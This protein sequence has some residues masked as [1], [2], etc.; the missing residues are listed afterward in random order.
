[1]S[2]SSDRQRLKIAHVLPALTKGGA[3]K[4]VVDLANHF[5]TSAEV[6]ILAGCPTDPQLLQA[7]ISPEVEL[8]F[9][10]QGR[11]GK[12]VY[13][14]APRWIHRNWEWLASRDIIHCHL[15]FGS[16]FGALV[17][18][19]CRLRRLQRPKVLET[20]HAVGMPI[21]VMR[22]RM[23][24]LL[25]A[26]HDGFVT[27][28]TDPKIADFV[29]NHPDLPYALI[30]NGIPLPVRR[31]SQEEALRFREAAGIPE[32]ARVV[33]TIG[34]LVAERRPDKFVQIF[35]RI[36]EAR[37]DVHFLMAGEGPERSR[38]LQLARRAGIAERLHLPGLARRAE[39]PLSVI[40]L[41]LTL[42]VGEITGIAALEAIASDLPAVA[43][44]AD[45]TYAGES[46]W[47][48]SSPDPRKVA[49]EV[50]RLLDS[51]EERRALA[52][53][54]HE[55]LVAKR[56]IDAA[57]GAYGQFYRELLKS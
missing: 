27:M 29:R 17:S 16:A 6:A 25:A 12:R 47:I 2:T 23:T 35:A 41:Y 24:A 38:I 15:T 13:A 20:Y 52:A 34:R 36:A 51:P 42:N 43:Y 3:E 14:A 5:T 10:S 31:A 26:S 48:Y 55:E 32:K 50:V 57:A 33:G 28:A 54:Q 30:P 1:M 44:Q 22:W 49:G 18:F 8:R 39:L 46:D 56:S 40:D 4:V 19:N 53:A 7:A 37:P 21:G 9:V 45:T 11:P